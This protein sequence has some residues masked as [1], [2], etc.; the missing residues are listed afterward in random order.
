MQSKFCEKL[1]ITTNQIILLIQ[2]IS[3]KRS[4]SNCMIF[5][6][7]I[8]ALSPRQFEESRPGIIPVLSWT[9]DY[10]PRFPSYA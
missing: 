8:E 9:G 7:A 4:G 6:K 2:K 1:Q 5:E 10:R 3:Y